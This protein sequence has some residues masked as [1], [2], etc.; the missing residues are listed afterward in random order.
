MTGR[1]RLDGKSAVVFG[2]ASGIGAATCRALAEQGASVTSADIDSAR[3]QA[4]ATSIGASASFQTVDV[5]NAEQ[6]ATAVAGAAARTG[7]L[8][9]VVNAAAIIRP[10]T[11]ADTTLADWRRQ[12]AVNV[13]GVFHACRAAVG[14]M[15]KQQPAGGVIVN[16]A[17]TAALVGIPNRAG[18]CATKGAVLAFSR[19][20]A[21]E[22]AAQNVRCHAVCP[23]TIDTPLIRGWV[24]ANHP[25]RVDEIYQQIIGRQLVGRM[26][27]PEEV[28][29]LIAY[30]ASDEARFMTGEQ[31]VIDGAL[32]AV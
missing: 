32:T 7:R 19:Q 16:I 6:V 1:F 17:S 2:G 25:N 28:A 22:Y 10:G 11:L 12:F 4:L 13:E 15:L 14:L 26:G 20:I 30:L 9:I 3:G 27:R 24:E 29:D 31:F 23:G 21:V 5:T 8:D 18:Y